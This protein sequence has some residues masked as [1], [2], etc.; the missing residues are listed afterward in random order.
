[1]AY[2]I[3]L[4]CYVYYNSIIGNYAPRSIIVGGADNTI[5]NG[6]TSVIGGG[7]YNAI[8]GAY[9]S[10]IMSGK[11][12]VINGGYA[13]VQTIL[14][15]YNNT[16]GSYESHVL[17]SNITTDRVCTAFVNNLSIK[18]IPTVVT[19]LPAGSVWNNA[20]VLNIV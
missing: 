9:H 12:N 4:N 1:M 8:N 20:G 18:S 6:N 2:F 13:S 17:G 5:D 19:G 15:G 11:C 14:G 10:G 16:N 7:R 3:F